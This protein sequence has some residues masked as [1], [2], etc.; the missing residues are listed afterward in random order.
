MQSGAAWSIAEGVWRGTR[1]TRRTVLQININWAECP[2]PMTG[3][4]WSGDQQEYFIRDYLADRAECPTPKSCVYRQPWTY[5][6]RYLW[7]I[8]RSKVVLTPLMNYP[9]QVSRG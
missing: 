2:T 7:R 5:G 4:S 1:L 3:V 6:L 8:G 9:V